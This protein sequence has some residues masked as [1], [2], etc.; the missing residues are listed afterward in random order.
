MSA[1]TVKWIII[2]GLGVTAAGGIIY[3]FHN[4]LYWFGNLPG[5]IK[6]EK[7]NFRVYFP[8]TTM[9]IVSLLL[10]VII[11]IFKWLS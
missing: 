1:D 10:N 5:D 8:I 4:N 9:I 3:F 7:E 6:M 2:A 11:R